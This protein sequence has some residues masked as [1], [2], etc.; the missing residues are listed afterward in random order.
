MKKSLK[1][2]IL[3]AALGFS[4]SV[5]AQDKTVRKLIEPLSLIFRNPY[6]FILED[7]MITSDQ[8]TNTVNR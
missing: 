2:L 7:K 4:L 1:Y 5:T 6:A 8:H 3:L